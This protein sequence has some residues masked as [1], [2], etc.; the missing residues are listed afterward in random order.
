MKSCKTEAY[1]STIRRLN[2][3]ICFLPFIEKMDRRHACLVGGSW[4]MDEAYIKV[5]GVWKYLNCA[6]DK[7][8][9]TV[10]FLQAAKRDMAEST[11]FS[12]RL[13]ER[14]ATRT[15]SRLTRASRTTLSSSQLTPRNADPCV[16]RQC[17]R[18]A[19]ELLL[20]H[21]RPGNA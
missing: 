4:F 1:R 14:A 17:R 8:S 20:E 9:K 6:I 18:L 3:A 2:G 16:R 15:R 12:T 5:N 7:Q 10:E 19:L 11:R 13:W 21:R